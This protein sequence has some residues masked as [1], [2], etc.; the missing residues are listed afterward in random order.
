[1]VHQYGYLAVFLL[2]TIESACI[3]IPSEAVMPYA[4]Y[5][6]SHHLLSLWGVITVGTLANVVGGLI[7]YYV[8]RSGGR[9]LILRY[10]KYVLLSERHLTHAEAWFAK[11]GEITVFVGRLLPALRTFISLPAG[12][13]RMPVGKF[14]FYSVLGSLPWNAALTYAGFYLGKNFDVISKYMKPLTY[15]GA[16]LLVGGVIWFWSVRKRPE[17]RTPRRSEEQ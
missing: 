4:G 1:M 15:L 6:S 7:I 8:G 16:V 17:Q 5:L 12:I 14:V 9:A 2:M 10:G 13:A 11:R 3:P